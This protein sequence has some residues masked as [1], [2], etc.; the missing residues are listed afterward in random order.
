M[1]R[2]IS[3]WPLQ[4]MIP[5]IY[6]SPPP[7]PAPSLSSLQLYETNAHQNI[8]LQPRF[9]LPQNYV[10]GILARRSSLFRRW[11]ISLSFFSEVRPPSQ[12]GQPVVVEFSIFV[13][14]INSINVEDMD[15]R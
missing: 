10:K 7:E 14:D 2:L 8:T 12:K 13:V 6:E 11:F 1:G 4:K 15:Y 3:L 5:I 9:L